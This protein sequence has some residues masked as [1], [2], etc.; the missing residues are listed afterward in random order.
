MRLGLRP[1]VTTGVAIVGAS[2]LVTTPATVPPA[3][4]VRLAATT[5]T[6]GS[7]TQTTPSSTD[8]LDTA[9]TLYTGLAGALPAGTL[10]NLDPSTFVPFAKAARDDITELAGALVSAVE[11]APEQVLAL[12]TGLSQGNLGALSSFAAYSLST[13]S[14]VMSPS[15]KVLEAYIAEDGTNAAKSKVTDIQSVVQMFGQMITSAVSFLAPSASAASTTPLA[16]AARSAGA[17]G[18]STAV[19]QPTTA[20]QTKPALAGAEAAAASAA[21][22]AD[23]EPAAQATVMSAVTPEGANSAPTPAADIEAPAL[24]A[25]TPDGS[26]K[27]SLANATGDAENGTLLDLGAVDGPHAGPPEPGTK[28]ADPADGGQVRTGSL[29]AAPDA[30][31]DDAETTRTQPSTG[32]QTGSV[33]H[34]SAGETSTGGEQH[35]GATPGGTGT[36]TGTGSEGDGS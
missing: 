11:A 5:T 21:E 3:P 13:F 34:T 33:P 23:N 18:A 31:A 29:R 8:P 30:R 27:Y 14:S 15:V 2:L 16:A 12:A 22:P 6:T 32:T 36:G 24:G 10:N 7:A 9:L 4:P 28:D 26:I 20:A 35:A 25:Q 17:G 1:V 19:A